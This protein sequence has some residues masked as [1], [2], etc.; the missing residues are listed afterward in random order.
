MRRKA[1]IVNL[2]VV[3]SFLLISVSVASAQ[4][5]GGILERWSASKPVPPERGPIRPP[6][7][8]PIRPK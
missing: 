3:S 7:L 6:I 8:P 2:V 4:I 1:L 5:Q